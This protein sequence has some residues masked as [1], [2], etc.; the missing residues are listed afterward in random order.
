MNA[1]SFMNLVNEQN[2]FEFVIG[3]KNGEHYIGGTGNKYWYLVDTGRKKEY[4]IG[5]YEDGVWSDKFY[6]DKKGDLE[7]STV[8][9]GTTINKI[10]ERAYF[11]QERTAGRKPQ[12]TEMGGFKCNHYCFGF[13]DKA[14]QVVQDYGVTVGFNDIKD[15]DGAYRLRDISTG[16]QVD[17]PK[18]N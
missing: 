14:V 7:S 2:G 6:V 10:V 15:N 3:F 17:P 11:Y 4:Y 8:E 5:T 13:G 18:E 16:K 12:E 9:S 1:E